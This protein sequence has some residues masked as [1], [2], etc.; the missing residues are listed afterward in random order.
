FGF[1]VTPVK[2]SRKDQI[3][4]VKL[5]EETGSVTAAVWC[6]EH[7][8]KSIVHPLNEV[9]DEQGRTAVQVFV[10]NYKQA[11]LT[12]T[13]TVRKANLAQLMK[14]KAQQAL[15]GASSAGRRES[16]ANSIA[17]A[18]R[19]GAR[20][21]LAA[22]ETK[23]AEAKVEAKSENEETTAPVTDTRVTAADRRCIKCKIDV[24]PRWHTL[25][26]T[27]PPTPPKSP[28]QRRLSMTLGEY[29]DLQRERS[30]DGARTNAI[31]DATAPPS[32]RPPLLERSGSQ[33]NVRSISSLNGDSQGVL[34]QPQTNN[35]VMPSREEPPPQTNG[36]T[37]SLGE[38]LH[39]DEGFHNHALPQYQNPAITHTPPAE[40][41]ES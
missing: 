28:I 1:D 33:Q 41:V 13:G 34:M 3:T 10:E 36:D 7:V 30:A 35:I 8:V 23:A 19:R 12:L 18:V 16:T 27:P 20:T 26:R 39:A 29:A 31:G 2:G 4:T 24:T 37:H 6:K 40:Q 9:V 21:S 5:G 32:S 22:V 25:V 15:M 11:D 17:A 14:D 38:H